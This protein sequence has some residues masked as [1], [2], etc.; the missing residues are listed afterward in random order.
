MS[1]KSGLEMLEEILSRLVDLEKRLNVMDNNIKVIANSANLATL[2]QKA[3]GTK[4]DG[5]A[6]ATAPGIPGSKI[7]APEIP[8]A[9]QKIEEIKQKV[10]FKNFSFESVDAATVKGAPP[11]ANKADR[12]P[13]PKKPK[14]I[15]VK[16][17]L[18]IDKNGE[19]VPLSS[20]SVKI[21]NDK[22]KVVKQTKTNRAGHWMSQLPPGKYVALFE[23]EIAGKKLLP[24]NINFEVPSSLPEGQMELEIA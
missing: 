6:K 19:V 3:A 7:T 20:A 10:G 9:K 15:M 21:Y 12:A 5:W 22:D 1:E 8:D 17:K 18:K 4:L 14:S 11:L 23:G 2:I 24:Q 13:T 16:G